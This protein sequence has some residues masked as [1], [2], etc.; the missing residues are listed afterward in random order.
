MPNK[1]WFSPK[2]IEQSVKELTKTG[3]TV[4]SIDGAAPPPVFN[5]NS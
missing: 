5:T 2:L 3:G 4:G 1:K